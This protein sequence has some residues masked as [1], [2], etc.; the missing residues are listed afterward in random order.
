[1]KKS[2]LQDIAITIFILATALMALVFMMQLK[3]KG[4]HLEDDNILEETIE[5]ILKQKAGVDYDMTP[6]SEE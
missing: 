5:H 1:M 3:H 2:T 4:I 6:D